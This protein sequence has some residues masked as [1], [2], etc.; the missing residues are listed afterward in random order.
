MRAARPAPPRP[1]VGQRGGPPEPAP[2]ARHPPRSGVERALQLGAPGSRPACGSSRRAAGSRCRGCRSP[3]AGRRSPRSPSP[4]RP[5]PGPSSVTSR[6]DS[7]RSM[8]RVERA[9]D[10]CQRVVG[11]NE[12]GVDAGGHAARRLRRR[13]DQLDRVA[14]LRRMADVVAGRARRCPRSRTSSRRTRVWN[15]IDARMAILAA[16]SPPVTSSVGSASA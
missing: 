11:G 4:R 2:P 5:R 14:E 6:I 13:G 12:R 16:A 3:T 9:L 10:A 1:L 8:H 15:A 7:P